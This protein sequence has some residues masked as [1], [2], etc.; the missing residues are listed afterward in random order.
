MVTMLVDNYNDSAPSKK[1]RQL[2]SV[3]MEVF[4]NKYFDLFQMKVLLYYLAR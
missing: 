2:K 3:L 4:I 1:L